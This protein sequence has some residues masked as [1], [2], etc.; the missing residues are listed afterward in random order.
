MK[1]SS[2]LALSRAECSAGLTRED[3]ANNRSERREVTVSR[4]KEMSALEQRSG[5]LGLKELEHFRAVE[6]WIVRRLRLLLDR[7]DEVLHRWEVEVRAEPQP[8]LGEGSIP[9]QAASSGHASPME[10]GWQ[11]GSQVTLRASRAGVAAGRAPKK[12]RRMTA[13]EFDLDIRE[14]SLARAGAR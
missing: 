8:Y 1:N 11:N 10:G 9:N 2:N 14:R 4:G 7:A 5:R 12:K 13:A 3:L 6:R